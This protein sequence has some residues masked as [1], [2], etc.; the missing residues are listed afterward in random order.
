MNQP[1][2]PRP[3]TSDQP[4]Y[5]IAKREVIAETDNLRVV[6]MTLAP[7]EATPWH[8]HTEITDTTFALTGA[9]R[10]EIEPAPDGAAQANAVE[11]HELFP[12]APCRVPPGTMH[13]VVNAGLGHCSFLLV[14]GLGKYDFLKAGESAIP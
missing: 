14:Q 7:G 2:Q 3:K 13:R 5:S 12:G 10:V 11:R 6:L 8:Q 4:P 9:V 1:D